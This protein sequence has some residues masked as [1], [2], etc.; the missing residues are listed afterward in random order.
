MT[1]KKVFG[2]GLLVIAVVCLVF[3]ILCFNMEFDNSGSYE[4]Y[5]TYGADFYT[6]VQ[7]AA[8]HAAN[9]VEDLAYHTVDFVDH[10]L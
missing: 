3:S 2:I 9:A 4:I 10:I 6:D 5:K 8:A 1:K 7:H